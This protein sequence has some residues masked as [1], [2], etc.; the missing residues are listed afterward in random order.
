L[1]NGSIVENGW[2]ANR[3]DSYRLVRRLE[4]GADMVEVNLKVGEEHMGTYFPE[5]PQGY[6][7]DAVRVRISM[8]SP[9]WRPPTDVYET[10]EA[11]V[12]RV[13]IAGMRNG[14]FAISLEDRLLLIRGTRADTP[15]RRAY[16]QMEVPFGEFNTTVDL[17]V[18]VQTEQVDAT[19][20][21]GFLKIVLPKAAALHD[22]VE[23]LEI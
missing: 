17:P 5:G 19:Y 8:R 4:E 22:K 20:F 7:T 13:E 3:P 1:R 21:D 6:A 18:S 14:T 11:V 23:G 12:V 2:T 16:H 15:E 10:D 9:G